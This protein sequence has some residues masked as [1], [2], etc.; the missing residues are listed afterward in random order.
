MW[1][2]GIMMKNFTKRTSMALALTLTLLSSAHAA[3][4]NA[5]GSFRTVADVTITEVTALSFGTAITGK[6]GT[7]CTLTATAAGGSADATTTIASTG[8]AVGGGASGEYTLAGEN[9]AVVNILV[10]E[11]L[12]T[13]YN[14]SPAGQL[15]DGAAAT[16][17]FNNSSQSLTLSGAGAGVI[18]IGGVLT[19]INTLTPSTSYSIAYD[20]G[21]IY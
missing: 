18:S 7:I 13:D 6:G 21:V 8:C 3:V 20:I 10:N 19:V 1:K 15:G 9:N 17:F 5:T 14:F 4:F 2:K 12:D 11:V 16:A